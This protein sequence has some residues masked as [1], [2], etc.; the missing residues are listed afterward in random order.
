M[1]VHSIASSEVKS[2]LGR[3]EKLQIIDVREPQ[4]VMSGTIP[5]AKNI[6]LSKLPNRMHEIR[7]GTEAILVCRSGA[8][9]LKACEF[10]LRHGFSNVSNMAGGMLSWKG[11][12]G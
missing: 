1:R 9:S 10:L 7:R 2:R 4:E 11:P 8:R 3:G 5:G 12:V 6:P